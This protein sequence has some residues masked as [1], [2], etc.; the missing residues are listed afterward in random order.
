MRESF[1]YA[2][3]TL[4]NEK[5]YALNRFL[6]FNVTVLA[7]G[8][9]GSGKTFTMGTSYTSAIDQENEGVIPRVVRKFQ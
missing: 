3:E 6:G 4:C 7:Y 8:Q 2:Y 9:T 1:F 5:F